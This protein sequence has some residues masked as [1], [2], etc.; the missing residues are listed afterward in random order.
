LSATEGLS[1]PIV[2]S[3]GTGLPV[4]LFS[5]VIAFSIKKLGRYFK[6]V[7]DVEKIMRVIAGLTFL[8]AGLYYLNIYLK[9]I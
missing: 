1:L 5:F 7:Q 9:I 4:I 3:V 6:A 8:I 2:F